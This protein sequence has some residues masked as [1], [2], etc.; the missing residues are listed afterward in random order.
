MD[1]YKDISNTQNQTFK[2]LLIDNFS[3]TKIQEGKIL[4]GS[5][6]KISEKN[7]YVNIPGMKS[8]AMLDIG[9]VKQLFTNKEIKVGDKLEVYLEKIEDSSGNVVVSAIKANKI[10]GFNELKKKFESGE[11]IKGKF[12]Q[13]IKGGVIVEDTETKLGCFCPGSQVD[14]RPLKSF[15]HLMNTEQEFKIIKIDTQRGNILVSR[16][17][18][19]SSSKA[20]DKSKIIEK[21]TVGMVLDNC[22]CKGWSSFGT[23]FEVNGE[24][25]VLCHLAET[26]HS[27]ISHPDEVFSIGEKHQLKIIGI[28]TIKKQISVSKKALA[29]DPFENISNYEVGKICKAKIIKNVPYGSFAEIEPGLTCLLHSSEIS[30]GKKNVVPEKFFKVNQIIDCKITEI[31]KEKK[32][33]AISHKLVTEN[34][35]ESFAKKYGVGS[36]IKVKISNIKDLSM[37][38]EFEEFNITGFCHANDLSYSG[39][40]EDDVKK[41]KKGDEIEVKVLEIKPEDQRVKFGVKQLGNDPFEIFKD[42]KVNDIITVKVKATNSKGIMVSPEG[43]ALEFLIKKSELAINA[44]EAR[45]YN[46]FQI[47]DRLDVAISDISF[48][49]R[50]VSLSVKLLEKN[51]NAEAVSKFGSNVSGKN[52]PFSSLSEKLDNKKKEDK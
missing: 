18:V 43:N 14:T 7:I 38:A 47:G 33:V 28:D 52:L 29:P 50:K 17:E 19:I 49:K 48:E 24:I 15:D 2:K 5:I 41:F 22:I 4:T 34:P 30:W 31:D 8:E 1:I 44:E 32:R 36:T 23:F 3:K 46:R 40:P 20:E 51:L 42:K 21:Y 12:I 45:N 35:Y 27:R 37:Y 13:K 25:D 16:R 6:S 26:S 9:E 11:N 10:K 39:K